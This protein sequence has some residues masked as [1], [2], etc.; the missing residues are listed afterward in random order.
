MAYGVRMAN[1]LT[2]PL[3]PCRDIDESIGFY[4]AMG[5]RC[6]Y[7]QLRPNPHAVVAREDLH[8]HLFGMDGFDPEQSYGSALVVVP[9]VD[10]LYHAF[11]DG[12]RAAYG[13][14]PSAGIPRILRPRKR[15]GTVRGFSVVDPGGN[16]LRVSQLGDAEE[17]STATGLARVIENAARLG[18][19]KGA[20]DQALRLLDNGL[21]RFTEAPAVDRVRAHLYRAEL[22]VR[23]GD[24]AAARAALEAA[25]AVELAPAE[26][27]ELAE[28]LAHATE[29]AGKP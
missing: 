7:R 20:D 18:D 25:R 15:Q 5:F 3:L 24:G 12:L 10:A 13:R 22:A 19:A 2:F 23:M 28:E 4:E 9:D 29:L 11:A 8:L 17:R 27:D 21:A 16:W 1:E 6:T 26:R 14:L